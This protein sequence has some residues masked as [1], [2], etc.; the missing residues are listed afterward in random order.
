VSYFRRARRRAFYQTTAAGKL[1]KQVTDPLTGRRVSITA[2]NEIDLAHRTHKLSELRRDLRSG[3]RTHDEV[4]AASSTTIWGVPTVEAIWQD[5]IRPKYAEK[6]SWTPKVECAYRR[7]IE[8]PLG[9]LKW[10]EL[11]ESK[12]I[13][14]WAHLLS[15]AMS[16]QTIGWAYDLLASSMNL[17]VRSGKIPNL[18][19]GHWRP[20]RQKASSREA[21]RSI[22]EFDKI[23]QAAARHDEKKWSRGQFSDLCYR[24]T[25]MFYAGMRNGEGAGL[26]WDS[27]QIDC[28]RGKVLVIHW[29]AGGSWRVRHPE[30]ARPMD[31]TKTRQIRTLGLDGCATIAEALGKARDQLRAR[32]WYRPDGPVFPGPRGAWRA[33]PST[34]DPSLLRSLVIEAGL[35]NPE[36][37]VTHSLRHSFA[38]IQLVEHSGDI[39]TVMALTGHATTTQLEG[40]LHQIGRGLPASRIPELPAGSMP[41][42]RAV[43]SSGVIDPIDAAGLAGLAEVQKKSEAA[44]QSFKAH[45]RARA[46]KKNRERSERF[47]GRPLVN[48]TDLAR[49]TV[50][51]DVEPPEVTHAFDQAYSRAYQKKLRALGA[52]D[53]AAREL[54]RLAGKRARRAKQGAYA[55]V[56]NIVKKEPLK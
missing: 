11:T 38:T 40:Y 29:T 7:M 1:R 53:E 24:V 55:R 14:W 20:K 16:P 4:R 5:W 43:V 52:A 44:A 2:D 48:L 9:R 31:P 51:E 33:G 18:P 46:E 13:A 28:D 34:I 3:I 30:W 21:C 35:P 50:A 8:A 41:S 23:A 12:M 54:A 27:V 6:R 25:V 15:E 47:A 56:L 39:R 32:G 26:G 36:K 10:F 17:S 49:R 37:W 42:A 22:L 19:W 45:R